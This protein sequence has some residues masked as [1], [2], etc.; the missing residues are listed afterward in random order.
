MNWFEGFSPAAT[1]PKP[2]TCRTSS[3]VFSYWGSGGAGRMRLRDQRAARDRSEQP[4]TRAQLAAMVLPKADLGPSVKGL[5]E[6][7]PAGAM[8]N[9]KFAANTVDPEDTASSLRAKGRLLG[10]E[11]TYIHPR[12]AADRAEGTPSAGTGVELLD[13]TVYAVQTSMRA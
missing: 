7:R 10:H 11:R 6:H 5:A 8:T 13:G 2:S 12:L 9:A 1:A 4:V 3:G